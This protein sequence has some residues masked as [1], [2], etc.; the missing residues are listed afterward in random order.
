MDK[1]NI[2]NLIPSMTVKNYFIENKIKLTPIE[3]LIVARNCFKDIRVKEEIYNRYS[4]HKDR[5][6]KELALELICELNTF[7]YY[8]N[9]VSGKFWFQEDG[10]N[11]AS[12]DFQTL[13]NS[14]K[15]YAEQEYT[16]VHIEDEKKN[17][18]STFWISKKGKIIFY[19]LWNENEIANI[20]DIKFNSLP[21]TYKQLLKP[22][23]QLFENQKDLFVNLSDMK[24][25]VPGV[26]AVVKM[27]DYIRDIDHAEE[28]EVIY[29]MSPLY[30]EDYELEDFSEPPKLIPRK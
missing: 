2:I 30:L 24:G 3:E 11:V 22:V 27:N 17:L 5:E 19:K 10:S 9:D 16:K 23:K 8:L 25:T 4:F 1:V 14:V 13:K 21:F 6:V 15:A 20:F 26:L 18:V 12:K 7:K 28:D 29:Y